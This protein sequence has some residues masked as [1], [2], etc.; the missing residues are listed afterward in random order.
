MFGV[1]P[2]RVKHQRLRR[3]PAV[4]VSAKSSSQQTTRSWGFFP[5]P[6]SAAGNA[7]RKCKRAPGFQRFRRQNRGGH[8]S[9]ANYSYLGLSS[10]VEVD[11][12][13]PDIKYTLVGTAGGD[14]PDT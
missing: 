3:G 2:A 10:I 14:D 5:G 13:Q 7:R 4:Q 12:T 6:R 11:Y 1:V 9:L 8:K